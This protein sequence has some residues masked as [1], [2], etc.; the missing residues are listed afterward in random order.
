LS[1]ACAAAATLV[2][3][4]ATPLRTSFDVS[5]DRRNSF[6]PADERVLGTLGK[7]LAI[8]VHLAPEDP[9]YADLKRNVLGK[10]ERVMPN[11]AVS[12]A[13]DRPS[14]VGGSD[15]AYGEIE[16]RYDGRADKSRSTSPREILPL[17]YALAGVEAP[18]AAPADEFPGYPLVADAAPA[19]LFFCGGLPLLIIALWLWSR[20]APR[21]A[22]VA[23]QGGRS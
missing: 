10:L 19:L 12:L 9:R 11:V 23:Q 20:R 14:A 18:A 15:E 1:L 21:A 3:A 6:S 4:L 22:A 2:I 5:A 13:A 8:K 16:Y 17:I 7:Q